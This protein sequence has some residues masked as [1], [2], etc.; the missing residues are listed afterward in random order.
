MELEPSYSPGK[1]RFWV[2]AR[3]YSRQYV[4]ITNSLY[5]NPRWE[6]F[7]GIDFTL[8]KKVQLGVNVVNFLNQTGASSGIQAASLATDPTPFKNYLTSGTYLRPFTL[9]F[10]TTLRL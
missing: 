1:W 9:E 8:N 2:S 3:F 10:S 4:N 7:A 5:F 6:T